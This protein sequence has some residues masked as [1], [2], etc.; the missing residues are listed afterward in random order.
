MDIKQLRWN[1]N[2]V[3]QMYNQD[4]Y[5]NAYNYDVKKE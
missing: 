3:Q 5:N 4:F 1:F 2:I